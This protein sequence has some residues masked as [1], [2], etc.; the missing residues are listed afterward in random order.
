MLNDKNVNVIAKVIKLIRKY[1][2]LY[3]IQNLSLK[4]F[5]FSIFNFCLVPYVPVE[6]V[7]VELFKSTK[8]QQDKAVILEAMKHFTDPNKEKVN[9]T[10]IKIYC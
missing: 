3:G 9:I 10:I 2:G 6:E 4:E 8:T 7:I 1:I 5:T